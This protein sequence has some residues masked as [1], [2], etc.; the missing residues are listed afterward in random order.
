MRGMG[1][2]QLY[3]ML[4]TAVQVLAVSRRIGRRGT[5]SNTYNG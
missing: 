2:S 3:L 5:P 4:Q 1:F